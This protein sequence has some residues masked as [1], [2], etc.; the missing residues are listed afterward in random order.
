MRQKPRI[1]QGIQKQGIQFIQT[2]QINGQLASSAMTTPRLF[3]GQR[4]GSTRWVP[5]LTGRS[6][7]DSLDRGHAG[8]RR[9]CL[10]SPDR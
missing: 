6:C 2:D 7:P 3:Y 1:K 5:H 9:S 10:G 4:N 8:L